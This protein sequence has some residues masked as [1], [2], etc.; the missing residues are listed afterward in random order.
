MI[1]PGFQLKLGRFDDPLSVYFDKVSDE[2][3]VQV[4]WPTKA[5]LNEQECI[6]LMT[7]FERCLD[8]FRKRAKVEAA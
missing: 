7:F 8:E 1:E 6:E 5:F 4:H 3:Q 2:D